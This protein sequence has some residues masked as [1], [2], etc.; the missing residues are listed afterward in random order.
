M[1]GGGAKEIS[2]VPDVYHDDHGRR[3][4]PVWMALWETAGGLGKKRTAKM[5]KGAW[6][7]RE[8]PRVLLGEAPVRH[9]LWKMSVPSIFGI[10][11][12]NLY[13]VSD[14]I[15]ISQGAGTAAVGGVSVSFPLFLFLS[16]F[17][18]TLGNG[19]VS[20]ISRALGQKDQGRAERAAANTVGLFY[21]AALLVT[22][23]GLLFLEPLLRGNGDY[24]DVTPICERLYKDHPDRG[25]YQYRIFQPDP[26]GRR[27]QIRY[28][29]VGHSDAGKYRAGCGI[30][31][32][33]TL[34][35][36]WRGGWDC[37][38]TKYLYVDELVLFFPVREKCASHPAETF[39]TRQKNTLGNPLHW[40]F[41]F[42]VNEWGRDFAAHIISVENRIACVA[43]RLLLNRHIVFQCL[44]QVTL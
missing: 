33:L 24:A 27:Q 35:S 4:L 41:L 20:V 21:L 2:V 13:H 44:I 26:G 40:I 31:F 30:H 32:R 3:D 34:W 37:T 19:A 42:S 12:Y 11:A 5:S 10:M 6:I 17:S 43:H 7:M 16:A 23:A 1:R 15:F 29:P 18:S 14:T 28:A 22:A 25:S 38:C 9:A 8:E 39:Y 36:D